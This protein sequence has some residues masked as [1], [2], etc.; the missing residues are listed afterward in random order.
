MTR[1]ELEAAIRRYS[2]IYDIPYDVAYRLIQRE[3]GF[4]P[5]AVGGIGELGLGQVRP[6]TAQDPGYGVRPV[7]PELLNDPNE[8][9]R[10]TFEYLAAL[11]DEFGSLPLGLAGYNAGPQRVV[12]TGGIPDAAR[13]YVNEVMGTP[14]PRPE[15]LESVIAERM[16]ERE[17]RDRRDAGMD[18]F[19][20]MIRQRMEAESSRQAPAPQAQVQPGRRRRTSGLGSLGGMLD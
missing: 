14:T 10:F 16:A 11:R 3:S 6:T 4:N 1:E 8:N 9:L 13:A 20:N 7:D 17:A 5:N 15:G 2:E 19:A 12:E 18:F